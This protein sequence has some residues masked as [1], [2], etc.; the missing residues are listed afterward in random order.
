[1]GSNASFGA[2]KPCQV[3]NVYFKHPL[4]YIYSHMINGNGSKE[5]P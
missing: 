2:I 4:I 1:M 5:K 3:N